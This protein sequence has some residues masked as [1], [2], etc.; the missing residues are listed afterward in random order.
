MSPARMEIVIIG[1]N[2]FLLIVFLTW[3]FC[4]P[5]RPPCRETL[6]EPGGAKD[7]QAPE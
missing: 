1:L 5:G 6:P 3:R 4:G 7:A 2:L